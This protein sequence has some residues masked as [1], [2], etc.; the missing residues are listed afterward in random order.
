MGSDC[1]PGELHQKILWKLE[2]LVYYPPGRLWLAGLSFVSLQWNSS[3]KFLCNGISFHLRQ[4]K[5][6]LLCTNHQLDVSLLD[7][8]ELPYY[9]LFVLY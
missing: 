7:L 3:L 4:K 1:V 6:K 2:T 9:Q 5:Q 8:C